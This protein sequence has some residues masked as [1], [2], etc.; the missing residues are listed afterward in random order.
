MLAARKTK[1]EKLR[2]FAV[3]ILGSAALGEKREN[4]KNVCKLDL[5]LVLVEGFEV[6]DLL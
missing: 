3:K 1:V 5:V 6:A 2:Y 4:C